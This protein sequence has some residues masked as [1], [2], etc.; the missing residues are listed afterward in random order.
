MEPK[1][2]LLAGFPE[3]YLPQIP[4]KIRQFEPIEKTLDFQHFGENWERIDPF[5]ENQ[6]RKRETLAENHLPLTEQTGW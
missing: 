5:G 1:K 4:C 2:P 3:P 6:G